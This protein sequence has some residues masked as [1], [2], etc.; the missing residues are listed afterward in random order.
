MM[1]K[2]NHSFCKGRGAD[3]GILFQNSLE[4]SFP[5]INH[6]IRANT[7]ITL[8]LRKT[9]SDPLAKAIHHTLHDDKHTNT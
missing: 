9:L 5:I 3:Y 8:C 2:H 4:H 1:L 6:F 7:N